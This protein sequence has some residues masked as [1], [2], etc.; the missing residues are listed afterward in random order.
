MANE[1]EKSISIS[2]KADLKD[3]V[4]K[5]KQMPNVTDQEAKKMV[6]ALDRQLKQAEKAAQKS[7]EAS[8]K[9]AQ[10]A[11]KAAVRGSSSFD[12]LS[13]S[14]RRAEERLERVGESAGDIDRGFSSIGLALRGVNPQLAEAADGIADAMAVTEGLTMSMSAL[15]PVVLAS[16][17]VLGGLVLGYMSY[18]QEIEKARELTLALRDAQAA[19]NT[20][21]NEQ[22]ANFRDSLEKLGDITD[23]Y[24]VLTG[25]IDE[26]ELA[27]RKTERQVKASFQGNI[28]QQAQLIEQ[29]RQE[30][31][32]VE[33]IRQSNLGSV[34][35]AYALSE[36]EKETLKQ[37]QLQIKGV[38]KRVDLTAHDMA[39]NNELSKIYKALTNEIAKQEQGMAI[40]VK[41]QSDAVDMALQ[42]QEHENESAKG[43]EAQIKP[44]EK[45]VELQQKELDTLEEQI[46]AENK[47]F[48]MVQNQQKQVEAAEQKLEEFRLNAITKKEDQEKLAFRRKLE[49]IYELGKV[50]QNDELAQDVIKA[51]LHKKELER[52]DELKE[53]RREAAQE[54]LDALFQAGEAFAELIEERIK[55]QEIDVEADRKKQ[56]ELANMSAIERQAHEQKKKQM[57]GLFNFRKGMAIAE[58]AMGTAEAVIAAQKLLPPFNA[59][60]TAI[61]VATG[62]AQAGV[63]MSQ[64]P[65]QF[66]MGGM[67]ND[68]MGTRVLKGEAVLDRATVRRLGGESGVRQLQQNQAPGNQVMVIQPFKHFGRFTREIGLK[69]PQRTGIAGY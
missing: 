10:E 5:L 26:Y 23:E 7:A 59:I 36:A 37:L 48:D 51:E 2:Y 62:A 67:A 27:L 40:L 61:A 11:A 8:K 1:V 29:R 24:A 17:A 34:A 25:Q 22:E 4:S 19:L 53:K 65:P 60:Q 66:H 38:N 13:D 68:E 9:A 18:Q 20:M 32:L 56:E 64:Q 57:V 45:K 54:N 58:I 41:H 3:L 21:Y 69:P 12:D 44:A 6:A 42:I 15:N 49:E 55:G 43:K 14:A 28:D 50:A 46:E 52:I 35:D 39:N 31:A 33:N 47:Y 30:L 16:A 63:V